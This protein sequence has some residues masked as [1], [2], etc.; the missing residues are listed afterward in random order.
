MGRKG[1]LLCP[2]RVGLNDSGHKTEGFVNASEYERC[3]LP[4]LPAMKYIWIIF[5]FSFLALAIYHFWRSFQKIA[6]FSNKGGVKTFNG[7]PLGI[8]EFINDFNAYLDT[9]NQDNRAINFIAGVGYLLA[10]FSAFVSY[11]FL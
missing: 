8:E 4:S 1:N 11:F 3:S 10:S 6:P 9:L 7:V 5:T 2:F